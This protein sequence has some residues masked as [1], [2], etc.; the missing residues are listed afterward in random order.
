MMIKE[1][2]EFKLRV[3]QNTPTNAAPSHVYHQLADGRRVPVEMGGLVELALF[4]FGG[5]LVD[6]IEESIAPAQFGLN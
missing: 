3:A 1:Q 5:K 6:A 4:E 2:T